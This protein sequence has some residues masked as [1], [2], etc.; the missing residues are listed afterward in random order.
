MISEW[1]RGATP[2][3]LNTP[4][5]SA[6]NT[7]LRGVVVSVLKTPDAA[8]EDEMFYEIAWKNPLMSS[9]VGELAYHFTVVSEFDII[10]FIGSAKRRNKT[11]SH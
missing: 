8:P 11:W 2:L 3:E 5:I 7:R 9:E 10:S 1:E 6:R 4:V